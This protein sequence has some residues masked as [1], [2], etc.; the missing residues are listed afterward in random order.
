MSHDQNVNAAD[1][2]NALSFRVAWSDSSV[3]LA[4]VLQGGKGRAKRLTWEASVKWEHGCRGGQNPPVRNR[5]MRK[6]PVYASNGPWGV[7]YHV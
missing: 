6:R 1:E 3:C 2:K 4:M 5:V 7:R